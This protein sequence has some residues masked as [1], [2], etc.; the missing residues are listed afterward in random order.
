MYFYQFISNSPFLTFFLAYLIAS[1]V[2]TI[3]KRFLR[4]L[5]IKKNGWPPNHCDADGCFKEDAQ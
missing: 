1:T 5:D 4:H 3:V 2:G